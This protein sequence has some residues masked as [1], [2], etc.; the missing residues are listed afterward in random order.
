MDMLV[1]NETAADMLV[2]PERVITELFQIC[3]WLLNYLRYGFLL[4][5]Y[6][7]SFQ[8]PESF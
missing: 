3:L 8:G 5:Q 2:I 1:I 4:G 6:Y 7:C